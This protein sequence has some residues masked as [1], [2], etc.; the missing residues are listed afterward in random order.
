MTSATRKTARVLYLVAAWAVATPI[1]LPILLWAEARNR[2]ARLR[3]RWRA[4]KAAPLRSER[5]IVR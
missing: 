2:L 1:I 5:S 4:S 3:C